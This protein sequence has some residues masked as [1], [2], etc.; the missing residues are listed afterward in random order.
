MVVDGYNIY[1]KFKIGGKI[2]LKIFYF[3]LDFFF[4]IPYNIIVV[5]KST[6]YGNKNFESRDTDP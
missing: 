1:K 6:Y 2:F 5:R 3:D 4:Q